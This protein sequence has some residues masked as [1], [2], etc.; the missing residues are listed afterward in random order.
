ME[1]SLPPAPYL[2]GFPYLR[3][4][5]GKLPDSLTVGLGAASGA[6]EL[7]LAGT[8]V[9][10]ATQTNRESSVWNVS[11]GSVTGHENILIGYLSDEDRFRSI[12]DS[13]LVVP[14]K[15]GQ[16]AI[17]K[18][19]PLLPSALRD[20]VVIQAVKNAEGGTTYV[21]LGSNE[22]AFSRFINFF[23][24]YNGA[25]M[26]KGQLAV[27]EKGGRLVCIDTSSR[28][29]RSAAEDDEMARYQPSM[30]WVA[31]FIGIVILI[32]AIYVG[33]KFVKR[34]VPKSKGK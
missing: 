17:K 28:A 5:D 15:L 4:Q 16:P 20:A 3:G 34:R 10:R 8:L 22:A 7:S 18:G 11:A 14:S 30:N 1:G 32:L 19:I 6:N 27:F 23:T 2:E 25:N 24:C 31:I 29:A 33:S 9:A 26:L 21:I 13:L 12:S